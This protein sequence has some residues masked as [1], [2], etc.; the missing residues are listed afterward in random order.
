M[1]GTGGAVPRKQPE[2]RR[3]RSVAKRTT[4]LPEKMG[5][6]GR[7]AG[8][9]AAGKHDCRRVVY[10][11]GAF[12]A[13]SMHIGKWQRRRRCAEYAD[14]GLANARRSWSRRRREGG[15]G[16]GGC[17]DGDVPVGSK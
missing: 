3:R 4:T 9:R 7:V 11:D 14:A 6:L 12:F 17:A 13:T 8:D 5:L 10:A 16:K 15:G 1:D 2:R